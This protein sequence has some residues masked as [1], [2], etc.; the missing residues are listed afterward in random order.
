M[1]IYPN[2]VSGAAYAQPLV[3]QLLVGIGDPIDLTDGVCECI[4]ASMAVPIIRPTAKTSTF[5]SK[6][7]IRGRST[8]RSEVRTIKRLD[9]HG[10]R[11]CSTRM[12]RKHYCS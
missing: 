5:F 9:G 8:S 3:E 12:G 6:S 4:S 11:L 10:L 7:P 1:V 2:N